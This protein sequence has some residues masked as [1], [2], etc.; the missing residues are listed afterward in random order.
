[1][2]LRDARIG[3]AAEW[4][5]FAGFS[6]LAKMRRLKKELDRL[7]FQKRKR[8]AELQQ[9]VGSTQFLSI[10]QRLIQL[11]QAGGGP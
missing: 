7:H 5:L 2:E 6:A 9:D 3:V 8:M 11:G 1:M 4:N 10:A